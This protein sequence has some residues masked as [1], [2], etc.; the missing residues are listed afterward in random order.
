MNI[1]DEIIEKNYSIFLSKLQNIGVDTSQMEEQ[2]NQVLAKASFSLSN[3]NG[4]ACNG[5]LIHVTLRILTPFAIKLNSILP[6]DMK[7]DVASIVKVCLLSHIS[8]CT[9]FIPNDNDWEVQKRGLLYKYAPTNVGLKMGNRSVL[10][11]VDFGIK[12]TPEE[13]EAMIVLDR[14]EELQTKYYSSTLALLVKM[15]NELTFQELKRLKQT[16]NE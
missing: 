3:D 16:E 6:D 2:L 10:M 7:V 9:M 4:A 8:K 12:F 11:C 15:A 14:T 5:S 13:Y 1:S